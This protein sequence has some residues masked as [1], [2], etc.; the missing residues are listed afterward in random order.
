VARAVAQ[1]IA[2]AQEE[3]DLRV[4]DLVDHGARLLEPGD[5][6]VAADLDWLR[7]SDVLVVASPTYKATYTGLLKVFL[8]LV[9]TGALAGAVAVPVMTGGAPN[10]S[11]SVDVHLRPLLLE[12]GASC[13]APGLYVV[14]QQLPDLEAVLDVWWKKAHP[15]LAPARV[16]ALPA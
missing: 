2:S 4:I 13:P 14:E 12:L 9:P 6:Q 1:R 8:D 3:S 10:H 7:A 5:E 11:L 15:W 16:Q